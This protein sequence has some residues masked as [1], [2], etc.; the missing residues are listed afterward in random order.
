MDYEEIGRKWL[1]GE[2]Q[3]TEFNGFHF[4]PKQITYLNSKEPEVLISGGYRSGKTVAMIAKMWLLCMFFPGNRLLLG[5]KTLSDIESATMPAVMDVFPAGSFEHQIGKRKIVFPNGS[6]ILLYGLDTA[7]SGDDTKKAAQKIKGID[8]GGVFIDQLEE[9]DYMMYELLTSRLSRNVPFHQMAST[10]NPANFWAYDYFKIAPRKSE[11]LAKKRQ[12]IETGMKDNAANLPDGFIEQQMEKGDLYVRRFVIGEWSPETIVAGTVF[13]HEHLMRMKDQSQKPIREYGGIKIFEEPRKEI[14][15]IGVDPSVGATDPSH[16]KVISVDSGREVACFTGYVPLVQQVNKTIVLA[17]MYSLLKEPLVVPEVN[18]IGEGF[19]EGLRKRYNN[20]YIREVYNDRER[21]KMK[22]LGFHTSFGTKTQL[23]EHFKKQLI[24][25]FPVIRD[26]NTFEEFQVFMY[27]DEA[28]HKGAGAPHGYHDD[29]VMSTLLAY[30][31][32]EG[33]GKVSD[34][35]AKQSLIRQ[36]LKK[37]HKVKQ[38]IC[39]KVNQA[40]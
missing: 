8:L 9:V 17:D 31:H 2:Y 18:A 38:R 7:V 26:I 22:K 30:W 33:E 29:A 21:R 40:R 1:A 39:R 35:D 24:K 23:I 27:T 4:N 12:L 20:I 14:Y 28:K 16:I 13:P 32:V 3:I 6:E 19:V 25:G 37:I 15:Q 11:V 36:E 5:R 34:K 10:T